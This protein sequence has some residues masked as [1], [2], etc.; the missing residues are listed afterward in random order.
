MQK[1]AK[2]EEEEAV[3]DIILEEEKGPLKVSDACTQTPK[4]G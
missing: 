4:A 3:L 1:L 2:G